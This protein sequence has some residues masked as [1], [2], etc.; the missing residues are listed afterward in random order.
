MIPGLPF[1]GASDLFGKSRQARATTRVI[2]NMRP[3]DCTNSTMRLAQRAGL[4]RYTIA[5]VSGLSPVKAMAQVT[6][7]RK[8]VD[9]AEKASPLNTT[10]DVKFS[11]VMPSGLPVTALACDRLG[12]V[13]AIDGAAGVFKCNSTGTQ[14][15]K[16]SLPVLEADVITR[17]LGVATIG[18]ADS[19][20]D[21]VFAGIS[22]GG[23]QSNAK[24]WCYKQVSTVA[25]SGREVIKTEMVW[26]EAPGAYIE[27]IK[28]R[29]SFL[30]TAQNDK[31][32]GRAWIRVYVGIDTPQPSLTFEREIPFPVNDLDVRDTDGAI[33]TSHERSALRGINPRFPRFSPRDLAH[34]WLIRDLPDFPARIH[35]IFDARALDLEDNDTVN[36]WPDESGNLR[37]IFQPSTAAA[38]LPIFIE[39]AIGGMPAVR[40]NLD[41]TLTNFLISLGNTSI[42]PTYADQGKSLLPGT[43]RNRFALFMVGRLWDSAT[44]CAIITED[45]QAAGATVDTLKLVGNRGSTTAIATT[46]GFLGK[47][48]W[49]AEANA[50]APGAGTNSTAG[51]GFPWGMDYLYSGSTGSF[52]LT[53]IH[54]GASNLV[55][56]EQHSIVRIN[57]RPVDRYASLD[58]STI[59]HGL[60][61]KSDFNNNPA[62][63]RVDI[64]AIYIFHD[65]AAGGAHG[66]PLTGAF[67]SVANSHYPRTLGT[68]GGTTAAV[69]YQN[70]WTNAATPLNRNNDNEIE[71]IEGSLAWDFGISHLLP[72]GTAALLSFVAQP[73]AADTVTIAGVTYTFVAALTGVAGQVLIG[74]DARATATNLF[75]AVN[76]T[77]VAGV[78]YDLGMLEHATVRAT[79]F[80][81]NAAAS[82]YIKFESKSHSTAGFGTTS[83]GA[84]PP[85][86]GAATS[87]VTL[88]T[89]VASANTYMPGHYP[90]PF[91]T[92]YG[93]PR[94]DD[95]A[96]T[97][98]VRLESKGLLMTSGEGMTIKWGPNK[99]EPLWVL[100]SRLAVAQ[101]GGFNLPA[102]DV[103]LGGVGFGGLFG[104]GAD[105]AIYTMGPMYSAT[106]GSTGQSAAIRR[107]LDSASGLV[108]TGA[109]TW[110][111]TP[112]LLISGAGA[113]DD[114]DYKWPRMAV[115][116]F[117]NVYMPFYEVNGANAVATVVM[118]SRVGNVE[119]I[120]LAG[121]GANNPGGQ[122]VAIDPLVPDYQ[123]DPVK[124][125]EN[126]YAGTRLGYTND[127]AG[128]ATLYKVSAVSTT[129]NGDSPRARTLLA[130]A[131]GNVFKFS[132]GGTPSGPVGVGTM[133]QPALSA[134]AQHIS[135]VA[136]FGEIFL[137]DGRADVVYTPRL[138]VL[139]EFK[140]KTAG[141]PKPRARLL[142]LYRGRLCRFRFADDPHE[143]MMSAA[144]N[145]Y[146]WDIAPPVETSTQAVLGT[147]SQAGA[148]Q[149]IVNAVLAYSDDLLLIGCDHSIWRM[150]GDPMDGGRL[151]LVTD[152]VGCSFGNSMYK[153][154]DGNVYFHST[155]GSVYRMNARTGAVSI[156]DDIE[157]RLTSIDLATTRVELVW[158][159]AEDGLQA[160]TIPYN[161]IGIANTPHFFWS[162]R[163]RGWFPDKI[164]TAG[165]NPTSVMVIDGDAP[166][167]R[168]LLYG[169]ADGWIRKQDPAA[170]D[171]DDKPIDAR[172]LV[173]PL[174][175]EEAENE[176][177]FS[178]PMVVLAKEQDGAL[179][180]FYATDQPDQL[181]SP[182]YQA[183]IGSGRNYA[184]P[185]GARGSYV[186]IEIVNS[187]ADERFAIE[188]LSLN[189]YPAGRKKVRS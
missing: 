8:T 26:E 171:D 93:P 103:K 2:D 24:M 150:D 136:A 175:P 135:A 129:P 113:N 169:C 86:F 167:D 182:V 9:Y 127:I 79:A 137:T 76:L 5:T 23:L 13:Y 181:G 117:D 62:H 16:L 110:A 100:T 158:N 88:A 176:W 160:V 25:P 11:K 4:S 22:S 187:A 161:G 115:D 54:D 56:A 170:K 27:K 65:Y 107:S 61:C 51:V 49:M 3:L 189:A 97:P 83:A 37:D 58:F 172:V 6:I 32:N 1:R 124:R 17:A 184:L 81:N 70:A 60:L 94:K 179:V 73:T 43:T 149:D 74:A 180:R 112:T 121:S 82:A 123:G 145:P 114:L 131:G 139:R 96:A 19:D 105:K 125:A 109:G 102:A 90:H 185:C 80:N 183:D 147:Q 48:T 162:G 64:G 155:Q 46:G 140:S 143:W 173:G 41:S 188:S 104:V 177:R 14:Q 91:F 35:S 166:G 148:V 55:D 85:T 165:M 111:L 186:A 108:I 50:A 52:L 38:D 130:V 144:G 168:A 36:A 101:L 7:Q 163:T 72:T 84:T 164:G 174:A 47:M 44:P 40:F 20:A 68:L 89:V 69:A 133:L 29:D 106:D 157:G 152:A 99:A 156:S 134:S 63:G 87:S 12:N 39:E 116:T 30:Y 146:D 132:E 59:L 153:A 98:G 10:S 78:D 119:Y 159:T 92:A 31:E 138:D 15:W 122:A 53:I 66:N 67:N 71:R 95:I 154:E 21:A 126:F 57:G 128:T 33:L 18:F 151:S 178:R 142:C 77:G 120:W 75:R 141:E 34:E 42:S 118:I 28:V 45:N